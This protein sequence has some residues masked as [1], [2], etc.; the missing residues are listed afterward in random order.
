MSVIT[1]RVSDEE[2]RL[3][4]STIGNVVVFRQVQ[5][6]AGLQ[7][8]ATLNHGRNHRFHGSY[9]F[10]ATNG[11]ENGF[12]TTM[13]DRVVRFV[14]R[15]NDKEGWR[16]IQTGE[17]QLR[18]P[19]STEGGGNGNDHLVGLTTLDDGTIVTCSKKGVVMAVRLDAQGDVVFADSLALNAYAKGGPAYVSNSISSAGQGIFVVTHKEILRVDFD[20]ATQQ[21]VFKWTTLHHIDAA[22]PAWFV[23]RL[24]PGSGSTPT[25]TTCQG[26]ELVVITDG[27]LPMNILWYVCLLEKREERGWRRGEVLLYMHVYQ[28]VHSFPPTHPPTILFP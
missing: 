7:R 8:L 11:T 25:V 10:V 16:I 20:P 21:L 6:A 19:L 5:G 13:E 1:E 23:G 27:E 22:E 24:G 3:W 15:G 18:S 14:L 28:A 2:T 12:F 17:E 26:R 9:A 4:T